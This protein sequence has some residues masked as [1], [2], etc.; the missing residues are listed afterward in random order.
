MT[1]EMVVSPVSA[2][3]TMLNYVELDLE[4]AKGLG[5]Y[6]SSVLKIKNLPIVK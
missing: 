3:A 1:M 4:N 6:G 5:D 2:A